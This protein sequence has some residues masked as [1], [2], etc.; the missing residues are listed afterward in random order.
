MVLYRLFPL[1]LMAAL[2]IASCNGG[3][4]A[5]APATPTPTPAPPTTPPPPDPPQ[6]PKFG[7]FTDSQ[8]RTIT[9]G[10]HARE[11]WDPSQPRGILID[12]HGNNTGTQ[13]EL[14]NGPWPNPTAFDLGLAFARV[15][16]PRSSPAGH[17]VLLLGALAQ[18]GGS[19]AWQTQDIRLVH[20]LLQSGFDSQ[21]SIDY[22]R[23]VFLG[24]SFGTVFLHAFFDRYAGIYGGGLHAWCGGFWGHSSRPPRK[25]TTGS[26]EPTF[27]WTPFS[28]SVVKDRFKVFVEATTGDFVH[29]DAVAA[30]NYYRDVL[31]LDTRSDLERPGGHCAKGST[32]WGQIWEWLSQGGQGSLARPGDDHDADGDGINNARDKDDDNDGALDVIDALP[33][34]PRGYRDTDGDGTGDF[35]DRDADGDGVN[36]ADDAFP[37]DPHEW[38]DADAD[39]IGDNIDKDDDN[40]GLPDRADPEPARGVATDQ[41]TFHHVVEGVGRFRAWYPV[42]LVHSRKP[43]RFVY[44]RPLGGRQSY[45]Y[46]E[47]GDGRDSTF[48]I[49]IDRLERNESCPS[50]FLPTLCV[51]E[52]DPFEHYLDRIYVDSNR[53]GDLTDDGPPLLL[54]RSRFDRVHLPHATIVLK[55]PYA[56]GET[57][58]YGLSLWTTEDFGGG[59]TYQGG[60]FWMGR[61]RPPSGEPVLVAAV[62]WNVDGLF[63]AQGY[64]GHTRQ[65][66]EDSRDFVC[67]DQ[68]RNDVLEECEYNFAPPANSVNPG[69]TFTLDGREYR[70]VVAP[71]GHR[72]EIVNAR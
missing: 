24:G 29:P 17:P 13:E 4:S 56:S 34:D 8:G 61:I 11:E 31:R 10:L 40:D 14:S 66:V 44:P 5:G 72:V 21:L 68:N 38:L 69:E 48:Q 16:S 9:Y 42:A 35:A 45:Q 20:E 25:A 22:D 50:V 18:T 39:G 6:W 1:C 51:P 64:G 7:E 49:M 60:S 57:L 23:I 52:F 3:D 47:L 63:D 12:F 43:S 36:N 54:G 33:L 46:V 28:S 65:T 70:I 27:P 19:R 41:L 26:W 58:P 32:P 37:S 15:A 59:I 30:T 2:M 62:D 67:V 71:T 53:N 55:V